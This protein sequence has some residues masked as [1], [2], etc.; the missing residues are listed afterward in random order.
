MPPRAQ[1]RATNTE[2]SSEMLSGLEGMRIVSVPEAARLTN[3]STDTFRRQ[4][5]HLILRLSSKRIGVRVRDV[6]AIGRPL[7]AA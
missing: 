5:P 2:S 3:I 1:P 4:Y 6:L 7:N